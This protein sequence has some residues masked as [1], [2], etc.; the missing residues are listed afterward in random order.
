MSEARELPLDQ[1]ARRFRRPLLG[2]LLASVLLHAGLAL[3][4]RAPAPGPPGPSEDRDRAELPAA[5][6]PDALR[7]V[8]VRTRPPPSTRVP[9][10]PAPIVAAEVRVAAPE[11]ARDATL[12]RV[13]LAPAPATPGGAGA[14]SAG[15]GT[16][17]GDGVQPPVPRSVLPEWSPPE[18]VRGERI[19][20]RVFVDIHGRPA[21][22]VELAPPT[23]SRDFNRRLIRK[24]REMEFRPARGPEGAVA[25]WAELTFVF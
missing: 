2:G 11:A 13:E 6:R 9:P 17:S 12:T 1:G 24:V 10:P 14:G 3:A 4:W 25:A 21:G 18:S 8:A 15:A 20:V 16:G 7:A 19:T 23:S 22:P 5:P